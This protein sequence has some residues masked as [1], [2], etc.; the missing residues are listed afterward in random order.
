MSAS[1][2]SICAGTAGRPKCRSEMWRRRMLGRAASGEGRA[3]S[4]RRRTR[5]RE[6]AHAPLAPRRSPLEFRNDRVGE[7]LGGRG[8]AEVAR[9]GH[10]LADGGLQGGADPL[11]ARLV[12]HVIE[13]EAGGEDQGAWIG[14]AL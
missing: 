2:A 12:A 13:H 7:L 10:A 8:A 3:A 9:D 1:M 11:G 4:E 6:A 5:W 14:D